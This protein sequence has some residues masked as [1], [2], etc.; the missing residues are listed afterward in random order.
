MLRLF[1][2]DEFGIEDVRIT[3]DVSLQDPSLSVD[4]VNLHGL[5]FLALLISPGLLGFMPGLIFTKKAKTITL[6]GKLQVDRCISHNGCTYSSASH[7]SPHEVIICGSLGKITTRVKE[8]YLSTN[9]SGTLLAQR[10]PLQ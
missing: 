3:E 8:I 10:L 1:H 4:I 5:L 6:S 7:V 2:F 9:T